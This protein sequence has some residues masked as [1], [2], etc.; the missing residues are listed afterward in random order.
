MVNGYDHL[1]GKYFIRLLVVYLLLSSPE[2]ASAQANTDSL[3]LSDIRPLPILLERDMAGLAT[4]RFGEYRLLQVLKRDSIF[5]DRKKK[6][7]SN[8]ET[9][10]GS[11]QGMRVDMSRNFT[12]TYR[13]TYFLSLSTPTGMDSVV[14]F[15]SNSSDE[16]RQG[17]LGGTINFL[18]DKSN[19][20]YPNANPVNRTLGFT[21][22]LQGW[23]Y[24]T[25][26][27]TEWEFFIQDFSGGKRYRSIRKM[28]VQGI[29]MNLYNV[30]GFV[31]RGPDS[32]IWNS[33]V[34]FPSDILVTD[35]TRKWM[36]SFSYPDKKEIRILPELKASTREAIAAFFAI[37]LAVVEY[38][39]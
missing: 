2:I 7:G 20:I 25:G 12:Y 30:G 4:F 13:E 10:F 19:P 28:E 26:D 39:M 32:L 16:K 14:L 27:S 34:Y 11:E 6:S 5:L 1:G 21:K 15:V 23:I 29:E 35:T 31:K 22:N 36:A 18:F 38:G 24:V 37:L 9:E 33:G 3:R 17:I 8:F